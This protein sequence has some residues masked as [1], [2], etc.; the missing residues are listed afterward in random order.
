MCCGR[1]HVVKTEKTFI[2]PV[3]SSAR[4]FSS[5]VRRSGFVT[6][7][8]NAGSRDLA[9]A[10]L[11]VYTA[12]SLCESEVISDRLRSFARSLSLPYT[13]II[14]NSWGRSFVVR[15]CVDS[16]T[17]PY[18]YLPVHY[19]VS[20]VPRRTT[21]RLRTSDCSHWLSSCLTHVT[22]SVEPAG[23]FV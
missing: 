16:T 14:L 9:A 7:T 1:L 23:R 19:Q 17:K 10:F 13:N 3:M 8:K 6:V 4:S 2:C 18:S 20:Y 15:V 22:S 5:S 12:D 21:L 11:R